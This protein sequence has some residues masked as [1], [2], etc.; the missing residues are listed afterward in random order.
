MM[1]V[2]MIIMLSARLRLGRR[3]RGAGI[4][5]EATPDTKACRG[6][7]LS[8]ASCAVVVCLGS[9]LGRRFV[10]IATTRHSLDCFDGCR[11]RV[12]A[13]LGPAKVCG[14]ALKKLI[15]LGIFPDVAGLTLL[16]LRGLFWIQGSNLSVAIV[17]ESC[18]QRMPN[19]T[20]AS[21]SVGTPLQSAGRYR[22]RRMACRT[23]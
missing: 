21:D 22:Q 15:E 9:R 11:N 14:Q 5:G 8:T 6:R 1:V 7:Q 16:R 20:R 2:M 17:G 3:P 13:W 4:L 10:H 23:S 12:I 19:S 18:L